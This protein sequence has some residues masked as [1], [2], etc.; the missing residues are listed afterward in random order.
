MQ[1]VVISSIIIIVII[2]AVSKSAISRGLA[3][4]LSE[5]GKCSE[6][7]ES[8]VQKTEF[9]C[10]ASKP[11]QYRRRIR[12]FLHQ[13]GR[14]EKRYIVS[15]ALLF[16]I[17]MWILDE[18]MPLCLRANCRRILYACMHECICMVCNCM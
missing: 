8:A 4:H 10:M 7:V 16:I 9:M 3:R 2:V 12:I 13:K 5:T 6:S 15:A 1:G 14:D 17:F 18:N 11:N